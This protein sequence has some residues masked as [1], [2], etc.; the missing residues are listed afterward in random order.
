MKINFFKLFT[1]ATVLFFGFTIFSTVS[2]TKSV[3][4]LDNSRSYKDVTQMLHSLDTYAMSG[5]VTYISNNEKS[6][7]NM[8]QYGKI[9]GTYRI[10]MLSDDGSKST[11]IYDTKTI[12]QF[13]DNM[14]DVVNISTNENS[15]KSEIFITKFIKNYETSNDVSVLVSNINNSPCTVLE[16]TIPGNSHYF[17]TEKLFIDNKTLSPTKLVIYDEDNLERIVVDYDQFILNPT[18]DEE[19]FN[20]KK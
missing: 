17:S 19:I 15:E 11:T 3:S 18:L 10:E 7:Y 16:A 6:T 1:V 9:N 20:V 14:K 2:K 8:L 4:N 12:Y 13:N 5:N